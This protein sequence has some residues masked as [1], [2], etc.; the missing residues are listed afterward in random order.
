MRVKMLGQ[1]WAY[2]WLMLRYAN[3]SYPNEHSFRT[4]T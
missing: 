2:R 4:C 1:S 3:G